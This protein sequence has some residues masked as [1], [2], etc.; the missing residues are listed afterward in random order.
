[1]KL[2]PFS[3]TG[4]HFLGFFIAFGLCV[5]LIPLNRRRNSPSHDDSPLPHLTDPIEIATLRAGYEE[6]ARL[7]L[8]VLH[9]RGLI[10][11]VGKTLRGVP[12]GAESIREPLELAV[13]QYFQSNLPPDKLLEDG[14]VRNLGRKL[15][16]S[17]EQRGLRVP[18]I[19]T[20]ICKTSTALRF[21][22]TASFALR[23]NASRPCG[24]WHARCP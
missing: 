2:F 21:S 16:S 23:G 9:D 4:P 17:L 11:Q 12:Q 8:I 1:M 6:A 7:A 19:S 10:K 22:R 13:Y 15:E 18:A 14:A 3:L 24:S 20:S 5:V